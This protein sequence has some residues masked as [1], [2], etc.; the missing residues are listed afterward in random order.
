MIHHSSESLESSDL[1][2]CR[3]VRIILSSNTMMQIDAD[4]QERHTHLV[5]FQNRIDETVNHHVVE[6]ISFTHYY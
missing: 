2:L 5:A 1:R 6:E 4:A 3:V